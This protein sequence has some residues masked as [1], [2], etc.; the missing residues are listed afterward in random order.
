MAGRVAN[1]AGQPLLGA[2]VQLVGTGLGTRTG[3]N[4][5]YTIVNVPAGQYRLRTQMLGHRP[6]EATITV[7][8]GATTSDAA[9]RSS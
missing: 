1:E 3:E 6:V 5:R 2:Q 9:A 7:T 4:G 8:A